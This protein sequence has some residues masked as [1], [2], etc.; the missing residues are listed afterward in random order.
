MKNL[1]FTFRMLK[2]NP[3]LVFVNIPGLAIGLSAVL[4]LSVY[5]KHELSFDQHFATK[6]R[7]LRLYSKITESNRTETYGISLRRACTEIPAKV[8]EV[9]AVTQLYQGW[10]VNV[11]SNI[12]IHIEYNS[13]YTCCFYLAFL[14]LVLLGLDHKFRKIM[15]KM[16][17]N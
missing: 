2:R 13:L 4:L 9:E 7:V 8:P 16:G 5:L 10:E 6:D 1:R 11:N 17:Y 3:L 14:I 15:K 12:R